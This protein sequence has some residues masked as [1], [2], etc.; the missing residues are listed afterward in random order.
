MQHDSILLSQRAA[1]L[2]AAFSRVF[3][4]RQKTVAVLL[5]IVHDL[6]G[7]IHPKLLNR[8]VRLAVE[9]RELHFFLHEQCEA[10]TIWEIITTTS[11]LFPSQQDLSRF[12]EQLGDEDA[13]VSVLEFAD[14]KLG[15]FAEHFAT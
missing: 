12:G 7:A 3:A 15:S 11:M 2:H 8:K 9:V 10:T 5:Q 6:R 14:M 1:V 13:R 4:P